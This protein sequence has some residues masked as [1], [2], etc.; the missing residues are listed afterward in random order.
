MES[1]FSCFIS[2]LLF[3]ALGHCGV[4]DACIVGFN[5]PVPK[6]NSLLFGIGLSAY[7]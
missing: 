6:H 5:I 3:V 7:I 1:V 4:A 2:T